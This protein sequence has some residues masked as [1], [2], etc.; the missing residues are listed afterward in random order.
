MAPQSMLEG[1]D[2]PWPPSA[3]IWP[4][5]DGTD[6]HD[7]GLTGRSRLLL[8][9][10]A[11][12]LNAAFLALGV[13]DQLLVF[14]LGIDLGAVLVAGISTSLDGDSLVANRFGWHRTW[15]LLS[16]TRVQRYSNR[17][18][19]SLHFWDAEGHRAGSAPM[20]AL[21]YRLQP[22]A[23]YHLHH[24]LDRPGVLWAP[25][26]W[27]TLTDAL[28]GRPPAPP[29]GMVVEAGPPSGTKKALSAFWV[30]ALFVG[31]GILLVLTPLRWRDYSESRRIQRGPETVAA[32]SREWQTEYSG[33]S[34]THHTTH[35][36]VSFTTDAGQ[37]VDTVVDAHGKWSQ[38]NPGDRLHVR[39]DPGSPKH[40][41]LP[42]APMNTLIS[43]L[44]PTG[45]LVAVIVFALWRGLLLLRA[46]RL[47]G[48][49]EP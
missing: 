46:R 36:Q 1:S 39:Y 21:G 9:A 32:L 19:V 5:C 34:G 37:P 26:A 12:G 42:N 40:A 24:Y 6:R 8:L 25:G 41:E 31:F 33:R 44:L 38:L 28:P 14:A 22:A 3:E 4:P 17:G 23:A 49:A 10:G 13:F 48:W 18:A 35:F 29:A 47:E 16:I 15:P 11:A 43:V 30:V 27:K 20:S 45:L 2:P 7:L